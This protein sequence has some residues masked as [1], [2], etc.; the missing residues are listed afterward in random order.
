MASEEFVTIARYDDRHKANIARATL[1]SEGI[2]AIIVEPRINMPIYHLGPLVSGLELK[3][4]SPEAQRATE[5]L[6]SF[7][8]TK[9][10]PTQHGSSCPKCGEKVEAGFEICWSCGTRLGEAHEEGD[11]EPPAA[12]RPKESEGESGSDVR[13]AKEPSAIADERA[14]RAYRLASF[15]FLIWP[16]AF[17]AW[18]LL[19]K[20]S[21][22][23]LSEPA[24]NRYNYARLMVLF[25]VMIFLGVLVSML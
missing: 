2:E 24:L 19:S 25:D 18:Y 6:D 9:P 11:R 12:P 7:R 13:E 22:Q 3:V 4:A 5:R 10:F 17:Y 8:E 15:G 16:A 1:E 23:D 14:N 21:T 20:T